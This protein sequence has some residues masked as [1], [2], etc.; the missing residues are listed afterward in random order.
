MDNLLSQQSEWLSTAGLWVGLV[1][2]LLVFSAILGDHW[3]TRLGQHILV[4]ASL[5]YAAVVTWNAMGALPLVAELRDAPLASPWGWIPVVLAVMLGLAALE[6]IVF[7]GEPGPPTRTWRRWLQWLGVIPAAVLV[8]VGMAV[9]IVGAIQGTLAPQFLRAAQIGVSWGAPPDVL[10]TGLLTL[11]ITSGVIVV[12]SVDP[13]RHL[14]DQPMLIQRLLRGWLWVGQRGLW[15]AAGVLFARLAVS[16][17]SLLI[18]EIA[19]WRTTIEATGLWQMLE[20]WWRG[21]AG[22]L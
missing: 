1:M 22:W 13:Q 21:L 2:S 17:T 6:R 11:L 18:A 9:A 14:A 12:W 15:L 3:M 16:R 10:L 7:Q 19:F 5:G 4:G 20:A 8:G